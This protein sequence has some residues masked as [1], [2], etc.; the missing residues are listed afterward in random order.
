[1]QKLDALLNRRR[2]LGSQIVETKSLLTYFNASSG[3]SCS[4]VVSG[5]YGGIEIPNEEFKRIAEAT[6]ASLEKESKEL[7]AT[8]GAI[9]ALIK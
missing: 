8:I 3:R 4:I 2:K 6:L 7:D 1:M 5:V 9:E